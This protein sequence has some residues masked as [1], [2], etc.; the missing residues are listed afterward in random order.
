MMVGVSAALRRLRTVRVAIG[1]RIE[2]S[3]TVALLLLA[4]FVGLG[5]GLAAVGFAKI[6]D[7]IEWLLFTKLLDEGLDGYPGWLLLLIPAIGALPVGWITLRFAREAR[8]HGVPEVM[9]AVESM[10][11]RIRPRVAIAKSI[12]SAFTIGSGGSAG[13]EGPIVQIGSA[14][15]S[16]TGQVFALKQEHITLLL[17]CG[18][19]G[20]I[21]GT[22]NAPIAGMFFAVEVIL[23]RFTARFFSVIL[24]S[25]VTA[26][27]TAT[28]IVGN[29]PVILIPRYAL[30]SPVVEAP[31]YALLGIVVALIAVGFTRLLYL[32]EDGFGAMRLPPAILMPVLGGVIVGSL[33]LIDRD[34]LGLSEEALSDSLLGDSPARTLGI[35]LVLKLLA[36]VVTIGSGGSG[37]IFRPSL[38]MGAMIGGLF[39]LAVT[40]FVPAETAN[41][42]AYASVGAAAFFA[43]AAR[44]PVTSVLILFELTRDYDVVLPAMIAVATATLTSSVMSKDTI[45]TAKLRRRGIQ[46]EEERGPESVM[47]V[48]R[49]SE[50]M[51]RDFLRLAPDDRVPQILAS[52]GRTDEVCIVVDDEGNI[53]GTLNQA[54][55]TG[56]IAAGDLERTAGELCD[57]DVGVAF[58]DQT[59]HDAMMTMSEREV[60]SLPVVRRIDG[61]LLGILN[62]ADINRAYLG[63]MQSGSGESLRFTFEDSEVSPQE[64]R[65]ISGSPVA[66]LL[67]RDAPLP[68]DAVI[69]AVRRD[70]RTLIPRGDTMLRTGDVV[71]VV[72]RREVADD[73]RLLFATTGRR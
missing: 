54:D 23:R 60:H 55:L 58:P 68:P 17:A 28:S 52:F 64:L 9:L 3:P 34:V 56:V 25:S 42:G 20:G 31:L 50:A 6:I 43:G 32:A 22:F 13:K 63:A 29:E 10:G 21:A 46:I 7:G 18:A 61:Q 37:G 24:V 53:H 73:V 65:V 69:V 41:S 30:E 67:I 27:I 26:N 44:A 1:E 57:R 35:L 59:L 66:D 8:G 36:T 62:R 72:S 47:Q 51:D 11:G 2:R 15:G 49:V 16:F 14:L 40:E 48:L 38:V 4:V 33:A 19:A 45:Y 5:S 71:T 70:G 39:G 12:A